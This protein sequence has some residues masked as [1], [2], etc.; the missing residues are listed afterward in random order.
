MAHM[1]NLGS[2]ILCLAGTGLCNQQGVLRDMRAQWEATTQMTFESKGLPPQTN[3]SGLHLSHTIPIG[4]TKMAFGIELHNLF[5][6]EPLPSFQSNLGTHKDLV[7]Y[8][9]AVPAP[10]YRR[11]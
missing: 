9:H 4:P 2:L 10:F 3:S 6:Q 8:D 5:W 1:L 7:S 11:N